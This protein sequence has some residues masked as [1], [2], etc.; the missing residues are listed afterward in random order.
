M[1]GGDRPPVRPRPRLAG[2]R[3]LPPRLPRP[4]APAFR[5]EV[6]VERPGTDP[7]SAGRL[8]A[9]GDREGGILGD[10]AVHYLAL[11]HRLDPG[12]RVLGAER[13]GEPGRE[14]AT[15]ELAVGAGRARD[16]RLLRRRAP[17]Q[18][19]R[20]HPPR[21][22]R[23]A[24]L[25]GR[26]AAARCA[27]ATPGA[28]GPPAR[29]ATASSSTT[30]TGPSTTTSSATATTP[31]WRD[32]QRRETLEVA[33]SSATALRLSA[34]DRPVIAQRTETERARAGVPSVSRAA[35]RF[36]PPAVPGR[37]REL[38]VV[39]EH[40]D[41]QGRAP[42]LRRPRDLPAE[43]ARAAGPQGPLARADELGGDRPVHRPLRR[44][45]PA[46]TRGGGPDAA[47]PRG[48]APAGPL[49]RRPHP[50]ARRPGPGVGAQVGGAPA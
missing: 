3:A 21:P 12:A 15:V 11:C 19:R 25:G 2:D 10:H 20:P 35:P 46:R 1:A 47:Q 40:Q 23:R 42:R 45:R 18:P 5:L 50:R 24:P 32:R 31:A 14:T 39:H 41:G 43:L 44:V 7:L 16:R 9:H 26:G 13:R 30:S 27:T 36:S 38:D 28:A 8:A 4:P 37:R 17:A 6:E 33:A 34:G 49:A 29:S 48:G 22:R